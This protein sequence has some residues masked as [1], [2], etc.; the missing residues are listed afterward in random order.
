MAS[1]ND[2]TKNVSVSLPIGAVAAAIVLGLA[3]A[4]YML[5]TKSSDEISAKVSDRATRVSSSG[6]GMMRKV[7]LT[8]LVA[9]IEND[10]TR[11]V[12]VAF[13]RSMAKRA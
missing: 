11:K 12:V 1:E 7:G 2:E 8:A 6:R 10:A 13:L 9:L 4:A 5:T 3:G